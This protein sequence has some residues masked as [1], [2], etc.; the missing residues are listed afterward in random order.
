MKATKPQVLEKQRLY[1]EWKRKRDSKEEVRPNPPAEK[2]LPRT[3]SDEEKRQREENRRKHPEI[4][5]FVDEVRKH[6]PDAKVVSLKT[7]TPEQTAERKRCKELGL[8]M[9]D[10]D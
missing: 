9:P 4:A 6:F 7:Y 8:P 10:F 3:E 2:S 1:D 5:A